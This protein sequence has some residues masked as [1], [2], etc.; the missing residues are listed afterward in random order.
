MLLIITC[1]LEIVSIDFLT[2]VGHNI[3]SRCLNAT[4]LESPSFINT[5]ELKSSL[6][7]GSVSNPDLALILGITLND[8]LLLKNYHSKV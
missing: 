2:E 6:I 5:T 8:S 4:A 1:S 7:S 3:F